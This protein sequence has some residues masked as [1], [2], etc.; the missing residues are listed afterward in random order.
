MSDVINVVASI[1]PAAVGITVGMFVPGAA[2]VFLGLLAATATSYAESALMPGPEQPKAP[3][4]E[5]P[6]IQNNGHLLNFSSSQ[7]SISIIYG[8]VQVGGTRVYVNSS[9]DTNE[10]IH[11]VISIAEGEIEGYMTGSENDSIYLDDKTLQNYVEYASAELFRGTPD[12][13]V[14]SSFQALFP[15]WSDAMRHTA[16][17]ILSL[18]YSMDKYS[19]LPDMT[20]KLKGRKVYDPRTGITAYSQ[21]PAVCFYDYIRNKRFGA[22]IGEEWW[23]IQSIIDCANWCDLKGYKMNAIIYDREFSIDTAKKLLSG[24]RTAIVPSGDKFKMVPL[25]YDA[26]VMPTL[27]EDDIVVGSLK[28][29]SSSIQSLPSGIR[30]RY[31]NKDKG[32]AYD[33]FLIPA[34]DATTLN[35]DNPVLE[36]TLPGV[37]EY[38]TAYKIGVY[39]LK[40]ARIGNPWT[41]VAGSKAIPLE[42]C[43]MIRLTHSFP[44]WVDK[45]L[46]VQKMAISGQNEVVL[47]VTEEDSILYDDVVH[48]VT[49]T[50]YKTS[51]PDPQQPP[52]DVTDVVFLEQIFY[53]GGA[54]FTRLSCQYNTSP[55]T[56]SVEV[57]ISQQSGENYTHYTNAVGGSFTIEPLGDKETWYIKLLPVSIL[58]AKKSLA[59]IHEYT[60]YIFGNTVEPAD[61]TNIRSEFGN[62]AMTVQWDKNPEINILGYEIRYHPDPINGSFNNSVFVDFVPG[63]AKT[64]SA[65]LS[66]IYF[67]KAVNVAQKYSKNA[68]GLITDIPLVQ[69]YNAQVTLIEEPAFTGTKTNMYVTDDA[70]LV[71]AA[72]GT[73]DSVTDV[74]SVLSIDRIGSTISPA[75]YECPVVDLGSVQIARCSAFVTFVVQSPAQTVDDI[76][77]VD[78]V[79]DWDNIGGVR[80]E[81]QIRLSQNGST[82]GSWRTYISGDFKAQAFQ[83]RV[84]AYSTDA[85][86]YAEISNIKCTVDMP[87]RYEL[88]KNLSVDAAGT[89]ITWDK[90][91]MEAPHV[92]ITILDAQSGDTPKITNI[93]TTGATV[94]ILNAGVGVARN[95]NLQPIGY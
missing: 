62:G 51:L 13:V 25:E 82:W 38:A 31:P 53:V 83:T 40:R 5:M 84:A 45:P 60:R 61:V 58:G 2:G 46:R 93:T 79:V 66:G 1:L 56:Q 15:E 17:I 49:Q 88:H 95:V 27:T 42:P 14:S 72:D 63:T 87:E 19:Q 11:L 18:K 85:M 50:E 59:E 69:T 33:E 16:Y 43:D 73:I 26:P 3:N 78:A 68:A 47:I 37:T 44:G 35:E 7:N 89:T 52:S 92:G 81:T 74:D 21:N 22:G 94:Q 34:G 77:D 23:D 64:V 54:Y 67:V 28:C 6:S 12:Q 71:P 30:V 86:A 57:W 65:P 9:G 29:L 39:Y 91:F 90:P 70:K 36:L 80:V 75:Y 76:A 32:Y 41:F 4:F 10:K 24:F 48:I 55:F 8:E 20:V